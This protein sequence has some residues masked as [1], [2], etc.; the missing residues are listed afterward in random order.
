MNNPLILISIL[1][2]ILAL[3]GMTVL[4]PRL[5][6]ENKTRRQ[7][8][9]TCTHT[10]PNC[11]HDTSLNPNGM[12][13]LSVTESALLIREIPDAPQHDLADI[14]CKACQSSLVFRVDQWPPGFLAVNVIEGHT[15][16]NSCTQCR[17]PLMPPEFPAGAYDGDHDALQ[18]LPAHVGLICSRCEAIN[19]IS[20][21]VD[22]TRN[23]TQDGSLLCPRCY[24]GPVDKV[25]HF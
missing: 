2:L 12:R 25:H 13:H 19:C 24:R 3:G 17:I 1:G 7:E 20:C 11:Q 14:R 10:C 9:K 23:R 16:K 21:V 6:S 8:R 15:A 4:T 18:R 22:A 5:L